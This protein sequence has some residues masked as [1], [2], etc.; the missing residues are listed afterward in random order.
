VKIFFGA[1]KTRLDVAAGPAQD[2]P[3]LYAFF[4]LRKLPS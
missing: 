3:A 2:G 4:N 1:G